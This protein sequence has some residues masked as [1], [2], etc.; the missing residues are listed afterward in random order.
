M[1]L[2]FSREVQIAARRERW[3][4]REFILHHQVKAHHS[5]HHYIASLGVNSNF[6]LKDKTVQCKKEN[7]KKQKEN[8][9]G[10]NTNGRTED[11]VKRFITESKIFT[12]FFIDS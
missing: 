5:C 8:K 2:F 7:K 10:G 12:F 9:N 1:P 11:K 6:A 4:K 3:D